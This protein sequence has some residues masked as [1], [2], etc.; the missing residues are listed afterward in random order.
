MRVMRHAHIIRPYGQKRANNA[1]TRQVG[2]CAFSSSL[3]GLKLI[4]SK[5]RCLIPPTCG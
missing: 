2:L 5:W 1:C 4:Q 3:R